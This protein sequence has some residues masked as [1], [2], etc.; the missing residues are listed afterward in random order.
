MKKVWD[1]QIQISS[2]LWFVLLISRGDLLYEATQK[3]ESMSSWGSLLCCI[4]NPWMH[5]FCPYRDRGKLEL[6]EGNGNIPSAV[7]FLLLFGVQMTHLLLFQTSDLS[8][9]WWPVLLHVDTCKSKRA[10]NCFIFHNTDV[11]T[12]VSDF[13]KKVNVRFN[14]RLSGKEK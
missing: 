6:H 7:V 13:K 12:Y 10:H 3:E 9:I 14:K 8:H 4:N 5:I 1:V 11:F 2:D